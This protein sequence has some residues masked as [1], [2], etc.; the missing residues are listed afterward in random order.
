MKKPISVYVLR[1]EAGKFY[2]GQSMYPEERI[3]EHFNG[4]GSE[5]TRRYPPIE[6]IKIIKTNA[7]SWRA[8]LEIETQVTL[9]LMK[10]YG[11]DNV[12]GGGYS[13][14]NLAAKPKALG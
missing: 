3:K 10:I 6:V 12:R 4:K 13:P 1:L 5:W 8:A 7:F 11:W 14:R 2:V 9:E